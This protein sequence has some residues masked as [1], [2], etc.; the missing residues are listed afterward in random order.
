VKNDPQGG[1]TLLE[2]LT[3]M[4]VV[5]L[6]M[7]IIALT[8]SSSAGALIKS[9]D[10]ALFGVRLLR[11]DSL[12]RSRIGAVAVPYWEIPVLEAGDSSVTIPWYRG[13]RGAYVRLLSEDDSLIME[14]GEKGKTE[15]IV[16]LAGLDGT[17][18]SILRDERRI[19]CGIAVT[20]FHKQKTYHTLSAFSTSP[21][22]GGVP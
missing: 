8:I 4:A 15:R 13:E 3:A 18:L 16:L 10:R 7:T 20:Y 1:F 6:I 11:A 19:P 5:S 22:P 2:T 9:K 17:E 21:I 14:T 12:I